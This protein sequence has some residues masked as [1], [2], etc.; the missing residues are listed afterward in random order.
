MQR[1]L[2]VFSRKNAHEIKNKTEDNHKVSLGS[3]GDSDFQT[4]QRHLNKKS[5]E[6]GLMLA[7]QEY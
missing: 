5:A 6:G 3:S 2:C 7:S 4:D 1:S